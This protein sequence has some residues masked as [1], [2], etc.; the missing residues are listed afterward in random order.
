MIQLLQSQNYSFTLSGDD[1]P[2]GAQVTVR[3]ASGQSIPLLAS[4]DGL[5]FFAPLVAGTYTV[6]VGG[7]TAGQSASVSYRLTMD[8][9]GQQ[10]NAPPLVDGPAPALQI[11]L[12][13]IDEHHGVRAR[14]PAGSGG[15][16]QPGSSA[17]TTAVSTG[18][19]ISPERQSV[20]QNE[21]IG[22]LSEPG[23]EPAR[24]G[25]DEKPARAAA[26]VQ[27]ALGV[28]TTPVFS[29]LVSLVTLTQVISMNREGEGDRSG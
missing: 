26:P 14:P 7:W 28:P 17:R 9:V 16:R 27:V 21:A 10:D 19:R 18:R 24:R 1:L 3:N 22:A 5:V 11:H 2:A 29:G 4:S 6:A 8:L 12:D 15:R 20:A 23:H 25:S 13:G